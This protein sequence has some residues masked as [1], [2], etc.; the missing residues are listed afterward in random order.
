MHTSHQTWT[1][2]YNLLANSLLKVEGG[3]WTEFKT[4]SNGSKMHGNRIFQA[5]LSWKQHCTEAAWE[6]ASAIEMDTEVTLLDIGKQLFIPQP[7]NDMRFW[8]YMRQQGG[9]W[10]WQY[11]KGEKDSLEWFATALET[12][13]AVIVT[14]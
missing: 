8:S 1:W 6:P 7:L 3:A 13:S 14:G 10:M 5:C 2:F 12:G 4:I 9:E 11:V